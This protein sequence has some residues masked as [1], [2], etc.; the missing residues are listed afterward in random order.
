M[1][2]PRAVDPN[3]DELPSLTPLEGKVAADI[4][5]R[6]DITPDTALREVAEGSG[7]SE[8]MGSKSQRSWAS[9]GSAN[10]GPG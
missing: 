3:P 2:N 10:F 6:R 9:R 5:G 7:V 8:A 4:L 1:N